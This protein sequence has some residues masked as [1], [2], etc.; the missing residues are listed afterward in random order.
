VKV[1]DLV[2]IKLEGRHCGLL[3]LVV[4]AGEKIWDGTPIYNVQYVNPSANTRAFIDR[5]LE[6]NLELV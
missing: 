6:H 1:G 2:K 3:A 4:S 5:H